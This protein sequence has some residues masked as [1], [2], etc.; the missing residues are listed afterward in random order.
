MTIV[1]SGVA[2]ADAERLGAKLLQ[3]IPMGI[4]VP[5]RTVGQLL[6]ARKAARQR[7]ISELCCEP[8]RP[9]LLHV[10]RLGREKNLEVLING[11][12]KSHYQLV[13]AGDGPLKKACMN[14]PRVRYLGTVRDS[15]LGQLYL[16]ADLF[17]S[18]AA[19]ETFGRTVH[20]ALA[21]GTPVLV[22]EGTCQSIDSADQSVSV[23]TFDR[24]EVVAYGLA[25]RLG[26]VL[27]I[28]GR[29]PHESTVADAV[30]K[31]ARYSWPEVIDQHEDAYVRALSYYQRAPSRF[32]GHSGLTPN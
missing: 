1:H 29:P 24:D 27:E 4:S 3:Y 13:I 23:F 17:V 18:A 15:R 16:A 26:E 28:A 12:R 11:V 20:E 32:V 2:A 25:V 8:G 5:Y 31:V 19:H 21:H 10:G 9:I 30:S 22:P 7:I 14:E 6:R